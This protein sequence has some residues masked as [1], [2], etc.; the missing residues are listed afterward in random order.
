MSHCLGI[1]EA[2]CC[3]EHQGVKVTLQ[4]PQMVLVVTSH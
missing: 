3:G 4:A 1:T 2:V